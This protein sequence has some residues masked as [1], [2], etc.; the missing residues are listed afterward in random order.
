MSNTSQDKFISNLFK[1]AALQSLNSSGQFTAEER[2]AIA[3]AVAAGVIRYHKHILENFE[4][5]IKKTYLRAIAEMQEQLPPGQTVD[6]AQLAKKMRNNLQSIREELARIE[7]E[8]F[9]QLERTEKSWLV[10]L[11]PQG[12]ETI[13]RDK[14]S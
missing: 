14:K 2:E 7:E 13:K 12:L 1:E 4:R 9:I 11:T 10:L 6:D 3:S 5:S 8:G